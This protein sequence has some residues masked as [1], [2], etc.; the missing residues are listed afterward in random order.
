MQPYFCLN[1]I[2][3]FRECGWDCWDYLEVNPCSAFQAEYQAEMEH[4]EI[5]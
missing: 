4:K 2:K 1:A 5:N 3:P